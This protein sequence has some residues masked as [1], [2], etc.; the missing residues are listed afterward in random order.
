M[1]KYQGFLVGQKLRRRTF[2]STDICDHEH[3]NMCGAKI[4]AQSSDIKSAFST[5]DLRG[6]VCD[7]CYEYYKDEYQWTLETDS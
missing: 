2:S 1:Y 5:Y 7:E 6:W 4:S 3:C